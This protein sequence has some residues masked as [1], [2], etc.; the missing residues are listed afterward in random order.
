MCCCMHYPCC[1]CTH[2]GTAEPTAGLVELLCVLQAC[3]KGQ[4]SHQHTSHQLTWHGEAQLLGCECG[5]DLGGR[6]C[7]WPGRSSNCPEHHC[8]TATPCWKGHT[9]TESATGEVSRSACVDDLSGHNREQVRGHSS[10]HQ[11]HQRSTAR[12]A[13]VR[14]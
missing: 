14:T 2:A 9:C 5:V 13:G 7:S 1:T 8:H 4:P 3:R 12:V 10:K 6:R 11:W